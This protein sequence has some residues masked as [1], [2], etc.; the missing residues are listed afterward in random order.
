M[1]LWRH[2][3]LCLDVPAEHDDDAEQ[4]DKCVESGMI[5]RAS[6]DRSSRCRVYSLCAHQDHMQ[7][8]EGEGHCELM[9]GMFWTA[10]RIL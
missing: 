1:F 6:H 4:E 5:H 9:W 3:G 10:T 2:K 8:A 7:W